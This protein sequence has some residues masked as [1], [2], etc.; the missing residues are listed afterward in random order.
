V[1]RHNHEWWRDDT[2]VHLG[3]IDRGAVRDLSGGLLDEAVD[4]RVN[5]L[6]VEHDA[7]LI[8]GPVLPHEVVG[9]SGGTKY[10]FPG[11][12][13]AEMIDASHWLGALVG[14]GEIIGA[15]GSTPVRALI[16]R[17]AALVPARQLCLALVAD[18][19]GTH[20]AFLG[21]PVAAQA[22]AAEL[23]ARVHV[24]HLPRP[25]RRVLAVAPTRYEDLWTAAKGIYKLAPVTADG[26][27]I[28]LLA[29][30][31][32]EFSTTHGQHIRR[33]GYHCRDY[34]L[35]HLDRLGDVPRGVL[36]HSSNVRGEGR[37]D[38]SSGEHC[39]IGVTLATAIPAEACRAVNLGHR[40]P[41]GINAADWAT[42]PHT[43]VVPH[44]G[45]RLYRLAP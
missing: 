39:R 15:P 37:Y 13:G 9:F 2:F 14:I 19:G 38:S 35:A 28:V 45:E 27:E 43:L 21:P 5:R 34:L 23:S 44:A 10:L 25:F 8:A 36:A 6:A 40:D 22:A 11:L 33:V 26:G 20:G 32:K 30:H 18:G 4:V 12:S 31:V 24:I 17:A 7:I 42:D 16:D 29:P 41:A 3:Q 1:S